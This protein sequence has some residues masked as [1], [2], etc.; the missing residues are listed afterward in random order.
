MIFGLKTFYAPERFGI[1][2]LILAY[3]LSQNKACS[4]HRH[5]SDVRLYNAKMEFVVSCA[6]GSER[7]GERNRKCRRKAGE[8]KKMK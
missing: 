3:I 6:F 5:V 4:Y 2:L 1:F 8:R 7:E